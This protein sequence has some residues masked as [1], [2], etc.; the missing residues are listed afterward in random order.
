LVH[1]FLL[2]VD[3]IPVFSLRHPHA[4]FSCTGPFTQQKYEA[5]NA[6]AIPAKIMDPWK[7]AEANK[8]MDR[9]DDR[10]IAGKHGISEPISR[11]P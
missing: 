3:H 5:P 2:L 4:R 11:F 8:N 7:G 1:H 10:Q 6:N 9:W